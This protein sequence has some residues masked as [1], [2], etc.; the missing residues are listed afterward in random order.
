MAVRYNEEHG[1]RVIPTLQS[2]LELLQKINDYTFA[3]KS[4]TVQTPEEKLVGQHF[5]F[6]I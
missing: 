5:D 6:Q 1:V 2:G 3:E 4:N